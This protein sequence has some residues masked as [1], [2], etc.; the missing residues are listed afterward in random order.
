V[1]DAA[2]YLLLLGPSIGAIFGLVAYHV[3]GASQR[4]RAETPAEEQKELTHWLEHAW[5]ETPPWLIALLLV[6]AGSLVGMAGLE[7]EEDERAAQAVQELAAP[8]DAV[9]EASTALLAEAAKD[10][11]ETGEFQSRSEE[12]Q[13]TVQQLRDAF[14][15]RQLKYADELIVWLKMY[16]FQNLNAAKDERANGHERLAQAYELEAERIQALADQSR[17]ALGSF[18]QALAKD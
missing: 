8:M 15:A 17:S 1:S 12:L 16:R 2:F 14:E 3:V 18:N 7:S 4:R 6:G 9:R 10:D 13:V 5:Y 11:R